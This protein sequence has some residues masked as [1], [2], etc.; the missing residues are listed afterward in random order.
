[1][2]RR[3][4]AKDIPALCEM[5]K[6]QLV[7]EG[8]RPDTHIDDELRAYF[9]TSLA[10]DTLAE[11]VYEDEGVIVATAAMAFM[12]FPPTFS[13]PIGTRAYVTNMYTAPSHRGMGIATRMLPL[14]ID[15]AK[16]RGIRKV[17]LHASQMGRPL[18]ERQ[19]FKPN[20]SW[21]ELDL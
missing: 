18:Y 19:G 6:R 5:R 21:M 3:A 13:N 20:D 14:L 7:D 10:N 12:P 1:M 15:E 8:L 4:T 2:L 11:W 17:L 16:Q 9:E